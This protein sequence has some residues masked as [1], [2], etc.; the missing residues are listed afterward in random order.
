MI[1]DI[2]TFNANMKT[3]L[4]KR[5]MK[6]GASKY[7]FSSYLYLVVLDVLR[8]VCSSEIC[9][10]WTSDTSVQVRFGNRKYENMEQEG[11]IN[12]ELVF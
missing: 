4:V 1:F 12:G 9:V 8:V 7:E 2:F 10:T 11:E 6:Q 5:K 3:I